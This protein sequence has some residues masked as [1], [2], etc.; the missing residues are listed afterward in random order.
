M[1]SFLPG[2]FED[3]FW[4]IFSAVVGDDSIQVFGD[5]IDR[6]FLWRVTANT[7]WAESTE[8]N[9][10][11]LFEGHVGYRSSDKN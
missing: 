1:F 3:S 10:L 7:G 4:E 11:C 2:R 9:G 8:I 6:A 5:R